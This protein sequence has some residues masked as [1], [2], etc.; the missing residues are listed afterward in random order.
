MLRCLQ[1]LIATPP[2]LALDV[3]DRTLEWSSSLIPPLY[4]ITSTS[5]S[6]VS[7]CVEDCMDDTVEEDDSETDLL[8]WISV[9][10]SDRSS[11]LLLRYLCSRWRLSLA[12]RLFLSRS[13]RFLIKCFALFRRP[14]V[15]CLELSAPTGTK[16]LRFSKQLR[17]CARLFFSSSLWVDLFPVGFL[18]G[19]VSLWVLLE[20]WYSSLGLGSELA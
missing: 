6:S 11:S 4:P 3:P 17:K 8:L 7:E 20:F 2:S 19:F 10:W 14:R 12:D 9:T 5:C 16:S 18:V 13:S 1:V 15:V